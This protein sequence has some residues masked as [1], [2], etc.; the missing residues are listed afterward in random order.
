[1]TAACILKGG[2][3]NNTLKLV[4]DYISIVLIITFAAFIHP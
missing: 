1:M 3:G 4:I 2:L